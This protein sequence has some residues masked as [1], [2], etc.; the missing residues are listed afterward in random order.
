[1]A[2]NN[3]IVSAGELLPFVK[4]VLMS[5]GVCEG[6]A[7]IVADSVTK[8]ELFGFQSH[9]A[10]RVPHY[11]GRIRTGTINGNPDIRV[12]KKRGN[13]AVVDGDHGL[14]HAVAF[15]AM[16]EA[17]QL[18]ESGVGFV[19]VKNSSHFGI[20]GYTAMQALKKDMIGVAVSHTDASVIPFG[21]RMPAVGTNPLAVAV[22]TNREYPVLL[23]MATS[24]A[25]L[26]KILNA[27]NKGE[28][29]PLDWA[30]DGEGTPTNDPANVKYLMPMA[31]P[32]G[33]GLALIFD[34]LSGPLTGA[35][36]GKKLPLMYGDYD[37]RRELGHFVGA[38][39]ID[40]F[41]P[42][43]DFRRNVGIM[44]D[45]IHATPPAKGF[46]R[47]MV[48][49]EKEYLTLLKYEKEGIPIPAETIRELQSIAVE[50]NVPFTL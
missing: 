36:F 35:L 48:P 16:N 11:V 1:M 3:I 15:F 30:V 23:D 19:G 50:L 4:K 33:Y 22:P 14:G 21:G 18:A 46:D 7:Q 47:V 28:K 5:A 49:G 24:T 13:T 41:V 40:N 31:G 42:I 26:G 44:I 45:D 10:I 37:K 25:S 29:I 43:E 34:I 32:K 38:I 17:I 20:A 8:A 27:K 2:E 6:N 39:K 9:G 12:I